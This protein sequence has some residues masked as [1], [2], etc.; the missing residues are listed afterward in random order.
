MDLGHVGSGLARNNAAPFQV[1]LGAGALRRSRAIIDF[2]TS[3]LWI[4][5]IP[6][7][8]SARR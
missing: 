7:P 5:A 3:T 6:A 2:A 8:E 1:I 4:A